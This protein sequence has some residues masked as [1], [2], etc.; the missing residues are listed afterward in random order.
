[1]RGDLIVTRLAASL[2]V[3]ACALTLSAAA[4]ARPTS[5]SGS[6][7][8]N[9]GYYP[10]QAPQWSPDGLRLAFLRGS[11]EHSSFGLIKRGGS[12][13]HISPGNY[14][15]LWSPDGGRMA[16]LGGRTVW[17]ANGD[18]SRRRRIGEGS[19]AAWS[20]NGKQVAFDPGGRLYVVN[21]DGSGL[22]RLPIDVPTCETCRS[23]ETSPAW[24][25][26]GRT[27]AF[28]HGEA[29]P[30]S[31]GVAAIWVADVDGQN[32]RR[33]SEPF[34][35]E[36]PRWSPDGSKIAYLLYDGFSDYP[37]VHM[38]DADGSPD[39][40]YG[41][42]ETF[43]WGPHGST[44]A[45]ESFGSPKFV[46]LAR[47]GP[48]KQFFGRIARGTSPSWS[49]DGTRM[50][51]Q[52]RHSIYVVRVSPRRRSRVASGTQPAWSPDGRLIAY[53]ASKC[54]PT[55]G[56]QVISPSGRLHR[57]LTNFC[58]IVGS[59]GRDRIHGTVGVDR[60][61]AGPGNDVIFVRGDHLLDVVS[62]GPG[63]DR[64][65]ADRLDRLAGC[66]RIDRTP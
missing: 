59:A 36:S 32:L 9:P 22:R 23:D 57:R 7:L 37:Y 56:I 26:N 39:R 50:A 28:V 54:G 42:A 15:P 43:S 41:L 12:G 66:E 8:G 19:T 1:M 40:R 65:I 13:L 34:N 4:R 46:Y 52:W 3:T 18:G 5:A 14:S 33:L 48:E 47:P 31:K 63:R 30:G 44:L 45:Y 64:V 2:V 29:E 24:S 20:P 10:D 49:P 21:R 6:S 35:A 51:V 11:F 27:L 16:L 53:A 38:I 17:L 62:C 25:P 58:F 55:Q 60:V 61:L